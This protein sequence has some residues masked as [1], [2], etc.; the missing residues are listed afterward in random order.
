MSRI[1]WIP[2]CIRINGK[3]V[4]IYAA[5][6]WNNLKTEDRSRFL[7]YRKSKISG[8]S[9]HLDGRLAFDSGSH[10]IGSTLAEWS[11]RNGISLDSSPSLQE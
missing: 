7:Q 8:V 1:R 6:R 3:W 2:F 9:K 5:E 11:E 4:L 10:D